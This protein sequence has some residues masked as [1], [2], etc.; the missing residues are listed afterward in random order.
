MPSRSPGRGR[1]VVADTDSSRPGTR[2]SS[3]RISVPFPTPDGP[4]I[5]KTLLTVASRLAG[6]AEGVGPAHE[7]DQLAPLALGQTADRL[8]R[9][10]LALTQDLVHLH[11]AVLGNGQEQVEHLGR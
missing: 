4:V 10:D 11:P 6:A 8:A 2:S 1:R 9:R 5:T 3:P 7:R